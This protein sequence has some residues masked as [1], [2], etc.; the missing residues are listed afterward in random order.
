MSLNPVFN[1]LRRLSHSAA[2]SIFSVREELCNWIFLKLFFKAREIHHKSL[3]GTELGS[4]LTTVSANDVDTNPAITYSF[5][6]G[7]HNESE[8]DD[9]GDD[10]TTIFSIDK[11]S[12]KVILQKQLDFEER[13][14]YQLRILASDTA[15]VAQT[16]LTI[17]VTDVNDNY[18]IFQ[19][20]AY[21]SSLPG[22]FQL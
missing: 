18:P 7:A 6:T 3:L 12:G 9:S 22:E 19:Q 11:F 13:Q 1:S 8:F 2:I 20:T 21:H 4:V 16:T 10:A 5:M 14:E 17:R 15:H